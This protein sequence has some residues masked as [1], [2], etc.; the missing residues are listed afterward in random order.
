MADKLDVDALVAE[1]VQGNFPDGRLTRRLEAIVRGVARD[2]S[3]SLPSVLDSAEL[4]GAYRFFSNPLVQLHTILGPHLRATRE[5]VAVEG[6]VRVVH[7]QTEFTYRADGQRKGL[8]TRSYQGFGAHFSLVV[9]ADDTRQ[10][11]GLAGLHTFT[12]AQGETKQSYWLKQIEATA[13]RLE[14]GTKAV[15]IADRG[16]DDYALFAALVSADHRFVIR[17]G[18]RYTESGAGGSHARL[19]DVLATVEHVQERTTRVNRRRRLSTETLRKIHPPREARRVTLHVAA[20][21]VELARP[22]VNTRTRARLGELAPQL[23]LNV[24]RVWEPEAPCEQEPIEWFLFTNEPIDTVA[25]VSAV[26]DHYRARWTIEEYFKA[27]KT[28]CAFERRQLHDYEG[29][30]NA[31]GVFAPLACR[32]LAL[33]TQARQTPEAPASTVVSAAQLEVLRTLGRRKLPE[34]PTARDVLLA[35]AALGGHIQYAPD[36]GW[37]TITRGYEKLELLVEGWLAAKL[38][39]HCDQR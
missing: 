8:R 38:Q 26:V 13:V 32:V 28:G 27:L 35:I 36:P 30:T 21:S 9:S 15:H 25:Q 10:A 37:L 18:N 14:C 17:V 24:V 12:D 34:Q 20:T 4:E 29:L 33:R 3:G 23:R 1:M 31:L 16:A 7:D 19:R 6:R 22:P 5:R 2:P 11:L 39:L